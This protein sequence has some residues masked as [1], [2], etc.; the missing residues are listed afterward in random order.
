ME[1]GATLAVCLQMSGKEKATEALQAYERIRSV[2]FGNLNRDESADSSSRYDRVLLTQTSGEKTRDKWHKADFDS[3]KKNPEA[4]K[5][6]RDE[7]ILNFDA[8][9]NAYKLYNQT[10]SDLRDEGKI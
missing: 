2:K 7:K 1:D 10:V 4:I 8:E 6:K 3:L 9:I 5:L